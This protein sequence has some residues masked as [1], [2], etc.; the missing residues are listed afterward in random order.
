MLKALEADRKAGKIGK[1]LEAKVTLAG[2]NGDASFLSAHTGDLKELL[3]VSQVEIAG[4]GA[5]AMTIWTGR[6]PS[7][8]ARK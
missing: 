8:R 6:M 2:N 5:A 3:N 7:V 4:A 1:G